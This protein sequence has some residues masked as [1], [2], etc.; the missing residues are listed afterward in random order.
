MPAKR[1]KSGPFITGIDAGTSKISVVV[2]EM[3][4]EGI[5][6]L[7]ITSS[8]SAGMR[9]GVVVNVDSASSAIRDALAAARQQ[10]G[11]SIREALVSIS[12]SHIHWELFDL[13]QREKCVTD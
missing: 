2:A 4:D 10:S 1:K 12:G 9:K 6:I 13:G 5:D 3:T 8:P 11:V 7:S